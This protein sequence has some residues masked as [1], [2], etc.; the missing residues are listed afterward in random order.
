M[1]AT[2]LLTFTASGLSDGGR[3]GTS[4]STSTLHSERHRRRAVS[5][6]FPANERGTRDEG[7][8]SYR[9]EGRSEGTSEQ[10]GK[11]I[12]IRS[13][14]RYGPDTPKEI[15]ETLLTFCGIVFE[16]AIEVENG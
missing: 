10:C 6:S 11:T 15:S 2:K 8:A 14:G 1:T 9:E 13:Q 3:L 12:R 16:R 7:L 5:V 4:R